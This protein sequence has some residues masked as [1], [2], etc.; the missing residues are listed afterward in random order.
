MCA[1]LRT[2]VEHVYRA[3]AIL[4]YLFP[5]RTFV[6][7]GLPFAPKHK[8]GDKHFILAMLIAFP[9]LVASTSFAV[10]YIMRSA[11]LAGEI[12]SLREQLLAAKCATQNLSANLSVAPSADN[13][14]V[15]WNCTRTRIAEYTRDRKKEFLEDAGMQYNEDNADEIACAKSATMIPKSGRIFDSKK[16]G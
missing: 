11:V 3:D 8:C 14:H 10:V 13:E 5:H 15:Q 1:M 4:I 9:L 6:T 16:G 12:A 7:T 2:I